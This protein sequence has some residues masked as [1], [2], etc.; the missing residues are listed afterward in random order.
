LEGKGGSRKKEKDRKERKIFDFV[1]V[2]KNFVF[3]EIVE[4]R[5]GNAE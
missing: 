2:Q 3:L 1:P 5:K 4:K